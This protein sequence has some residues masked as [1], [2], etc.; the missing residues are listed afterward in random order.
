MKSRPGSTTRVFAVSGKDRGATLMAGRKA[1]Q[2]LWYDWRAKGFTTYV[3]ADRSPVTTAVPALA[4]V[5]ARIAQW[6]AKPVMPPLPPQCPGRIS[7]GTVGTLTV[8]GGPDAATRTQPARTTAQGS[9]KAR[10]HG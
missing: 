8:G 4:P 7:P 5:K 1:D 6:I 9:N 10:H 3:G 2:T